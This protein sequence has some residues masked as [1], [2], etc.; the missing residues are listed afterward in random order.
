MLAGLAAKSFGFKFTSITVGAAF[1]FGTIG[2]G[3]AVRKVMD[4][5][6][7]RKEVKR[8]DGLIL[9]R[10]EAIRVSGENLVAERK[11]KDTAVKERA[12]LETKLEKR[13]AALDAAYEQTAQH[14]ARIPKDTHTIEVK[15]N[16]IGEKLANQESTAWVTNIWPVELWSHAFQQIETATAPSLAG[17]VPMARPDEE[18]GYPKGSVP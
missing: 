4:G 5:T 2:G 17:A 8:L 18:R 13:E 10:D 1:L 6:I 12:R 15:G 16:D 9:Q 3:V 11:L 14:L 7:A